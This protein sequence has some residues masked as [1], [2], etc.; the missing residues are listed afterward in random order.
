MGG[1]VGP[2]GTVR[3]GGPGVAVRTLRVMV[4][5]GRDL[6]LLRD[7]DGET[8][9]VGTAPGNDLVLTDDTV[10]RYHLELAAT[11]TGV[12]VLDCGSTNGTS[13]GGVT[14]GTGRVQPGAVLQL[15]RTRI[16]VDDGAPAEVALYPGEALAGLRGRSPVMRRLMATMQRAAASEVSVLVVGESGTGKEVVARGLH[17]LGPRA[18]GPFV[19]VDCA[20]LSPALVASEL[21]GHERGAFT[22]ADRQHVGAFERAHGGT[23]FLD[24]L[25]ELPP[26]LQANLLGA[27]ER[28]RFRRLGGRDEI[29]IDVR[30]VSATNRDLRAE[31]NA[32]TFRLDLYYRLAVVTLALPPLRAHAEDLELLVEHF[33]RQAGHAGPRSELISEATLR[34]LA[35]HH[36]PGNVRELRNVIEAT[37]AMGEAPS[38]ELDRAAADA[39]GVDPFTAVLGL[40]YKAARLQILTQFEARYC[41]A[42]LARAGGNTSLAARQ[43]QMNRS[44]LLELLQRHHLK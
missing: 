6:G 30:V 14:L 4:V 20:A 35:Q 24:E 25:G 18:R 43:A 9:T 21:F 27:L 19:A 33:L 38:L 34:T 44:H 15:G 39:A 10:S 3:H 29:S 22:G 23:L 5:E 40:D 31:V 7:G 8:L 1:P 37:L 32:G 2:D 36:W 28:R 41:A 42:V 16:R 17:D 12:R 26:A 11:A 13:V